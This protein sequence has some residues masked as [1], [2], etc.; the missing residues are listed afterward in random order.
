MGKQTKILKKLEKISYPN[1]KKQKKLQS[2]HSQTPSRTVD[3][4]E[5][6]DI[7][8]QD[9]S[10]S[11]SKLLSLLEPNQSSMKKNV[12][13]KTKKRQRSAK[14]PEPIA[15]DELLLEDSNSESEESNVKKSKIDDHA[16]ADEADDIDST[17]PFH[18]HFANEPPKELNSLIAEIESSN[19]KIQHE[20]DEVLGSVARYSINLNG[21]SNN[22]SDENSLKKFK[23]KNRLVD[24][25]KSN[26][27]SSSLYTPLQQKLLSSISVYKDLMYT[28]MKH[29]EE[30]EIRQIYCLH[31]L[32][33]VYKTRDR[34]LKNTTKLSGI[35]DSANADVRDQ[36]FTRPKVLIVAPMRNVALE[37]VKILIALSGTTQQE[38]KKR[39]LDSFSDPDNVI[40][41][42]AKTPEDYNQTFSGNIDDCFRVGIK[43]SRKTMK[44]YSQFYS[45]DIILA[46]PL[47]LRI[48]IDGEKKNPDF[49][50]LSSIEVMIIDSPNLMVMQNWDHLLTVMNHTNQISKEAHGCDFSRV[51]NWYLDGQA[52][53]FRQT[54]IFS[55]ITTPEINSL[56]L[57]GKH[58]DEEDEVEPEKDGI[59]V[60]KLWCANYEGKVCVR[61]VE[62]RGTISNVIIQAPQTFHR[63]PCNSAVES[64]DVRF[65]YF[66]E[67]VLPGFLNDTKVQKRTL[68][69]VPNYFDF[70]RLRNAL[71]E[72]DCNFECISE[73]TPTNE[74]PRARS[75]FYDG[76]ADFLMISERFHFFRRYRLRGI[77]H[78]FFYG[79]PTIGELYP[80]LV[81]MIETLSAASNAPNTKYL[82]VPIGTQSPTVSVLFN[83]YDR[84][85]MERIVGSKKSERMCVGDKEVF[86]F[87]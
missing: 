31:A 9:S 44:L 64:D 74:I 78:I 7:I 6:P 30:E 16:H 3:N 40:D 17:D 66:I 53:Y 82:K 71:D 38:N 59:L 51:K 65:K 10:S 55:K 67:K 15:D 56:F 87:A 25:W 63:I 70:V 75:L 54:L 34:V 61:R 86:M 23:L 57:G 36:G 28:N 39:F 37:I 42:S 85:A 50:F 21:L 73:Y 12:S 13:L 19:W 35:A 62:A 2:T 24:P 69:F 72:R 60:S 8:Q 11:I 14:V 26:T 48:L 27:K 32:N 76:T 43:F 47:G 33:H 84:L 41:A 29:S 46:S 80:D 79:P 58:V 77:H 45:S 68:L 81:N 5:E 1:Y 22:H 52:K 18:T 49:D 4:T 20:D 83:R